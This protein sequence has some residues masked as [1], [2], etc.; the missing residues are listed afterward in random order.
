MRLDL[1]PVRVFGNTKFRGACPAEALEQVTFFAR[2]RSKYPETWGALAIHPR[3]EQLLR[4]GQFQAVVR[5]RAEGMTAGA[6]DIVI[7]AG[8]SFV[9]EMKR[10]DHTKSK[11]DN[12]QIKYLL[13]AQRAGAFACVAL[14][15]DAAMEALETWLWENQARNASS[16]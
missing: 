13:A 15:A 4:G 16:S 14:G 11:I 2:I 10:R 6:S 8:R 12:E 1:I 5:H 9:C 3:N 7:P